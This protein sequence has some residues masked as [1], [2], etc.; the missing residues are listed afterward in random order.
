MQNIG[1]F[2]IVKQFYRCQ[3]IAL[4]LLFVL[5]AYTANGLT[6]KQPIPQSMDS[7][8]VSLLTCG[9]GNEVW[10][11][12]GHT[13]IRINDRQN[14]QDLVI[15]YGMFSF[16]QKFFLLRFVLGLTDYSMG[17]QPFEEF[18]AEYQYQHR[19]IREQ[20]LNL[21]SNEKIA[22]IQ[23]VNENYQ[24][25]NRTYRYNYFYDNCTTRARDMIVSNID[26]KVLFTRHIGHSSY[27]E[28]VHKWNVTHPWARFG[29]DLLLGVK[30]DKQTTLS[31]QQFI[32]DN[33]RKDF[34]AAIIVDSHGLKKTLVQ[35]STWLI[36]PFL[37]KDFAPT[38]ITPML[39]AIVL[40]IVILIVCVAEWKTHKIW[41][42]IDAILLTT[43]GIAGLILFLMIF[44]Q[45]PTVSVNF[46]ILILCPLSLVF[47][48]PAIRQLRK[49]KIHWYLKLYKYLLVAALG[50][51]VFQ[52]YEPSIL[53]LA[54]S[55]LSRNI[56]LGILCN[57]RLSKR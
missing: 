24:I 49:H 33:L 28:Q 42:G 25:D 22:L 5:T 9:P 54:L 51:Y 47:A 23:A 19:W 52:K 17:I 35:K 13:A 10:S 3:K 41:Y 53:I 18:F 46:Q 36:G 4:L 34:G 8:E 14:H 27:R 44:S 57:K 55:L 15:N 38:P 31:E 40:L 16:R 26:G 12:Y 11:L 37:Q 56:M 7:I 43:S 48:F 45:H 30:A 39:C 32:P 2:C 29:N 1:Y 21:T 50:L 20:T 6:Y